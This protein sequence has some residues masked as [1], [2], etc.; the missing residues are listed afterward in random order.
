MPDGTS[1]SIGHEVGLAQAVLRPHEDRVDPSGL[2]EVG[3]RRLGGEERERCPAGAVVVDEGGDAHDVD[4]DRAR[5]GEHRCDVADREVADVRAVAVNHHLV[6][7]GGRTALDDLEGVELLVVEPDAADHGRTHV[8]VTDHLAVGA[9]ELGE[10]VDV[11]A[12]GGD[13]VEGLDL[14]DEG[15]IEPVALVAERRSRGQ[16]RPGRRRRCPRMRQRRGCRRWRR[17]WRSARACRP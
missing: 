6:V 14:V 8:G 15:C 9:D 3:L 17:W 7:G 13:A 11:A 12:G 1:G 5:L 2:G 4:F 10:A 16:P